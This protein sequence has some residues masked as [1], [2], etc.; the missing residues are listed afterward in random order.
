M[1]DSVIAC[2]KCHQTVL[3]VETSG[4]RARGSCSDCHFTTGWIIVPPFRTP[5]AYVRERI[6]TVSAAY[7][8]VR[9]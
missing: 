1:S 9:A 2:P 5:R 7:R 4:M 6:V 8:S 3:R